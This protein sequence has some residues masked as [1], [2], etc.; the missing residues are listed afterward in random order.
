MKYK[1]LDDFKESG[2][3]SA[4]QSAAH[5][6]RYLG[7]CSLAM[8]T[9]SCQGMARG[10]NLQLYGREVSCGWAVLGEGCSGVLRSERIWGAS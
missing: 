10:C 2:K 5:F 4:V 8:M 1:D 6:Q 9:G 7:K 3:A